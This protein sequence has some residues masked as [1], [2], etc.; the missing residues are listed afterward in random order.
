MISASA[1]VYYFRFDI[2]NNAF[3]YLYKYFKKYNHERQVS[4]SQKERIIQ[5]LEKNKTKPIGI[6][7][8]H[9]QG[10]IDFD[11]LNNLYETYPISFI[12]IRATAGVNKFDNQYKHNWEKTGEKKIIKGA[13][14]YY[15]P[16][17]NSIKQANNYIKHVELNP[18]DFPPILDIEETSVIQSM[19]SLKTGLKRWLDKI[20]EHYGVKPIIYT[21][22]KYFQSHLNTADFKDYPLWI[23]NYTNSK[24]PFTFSYKIW[25]FTNKGQIDGIG[26]NV[27]L[28][29]F[30]GN[31]SE[32][33]KM[34]IK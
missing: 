6:D 3:R 26:H 18:G 5:I 13:Y 17:E 19:E 31:F 20:E 4:V 12:F 9:Y 23:A 2:Q 27:D 21:S 24:A 33:K 30:N 16:N 10:T 15:R 11:L 29:V 14:H 8:S 34:L 25:Q 22:E 28:N 1:V 7:I 32:L